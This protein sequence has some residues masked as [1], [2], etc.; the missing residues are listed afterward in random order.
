[1]EE[2]K[3]NAEKFQKG[4]KRAAAAEKAAAKSNKGNPE[5]LQSPSN[6]LG[7]AFGTGTGLAE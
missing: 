5:S 3:K 1:M 6:P 4:R 2:V 7:G